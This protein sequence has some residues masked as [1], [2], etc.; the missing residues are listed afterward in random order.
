M[1]SGAVANVGLKVPKYL[2]CGTRMIHP[3]RD[4][5]AIMPFVDSAFLR[6]LD[7]V[8]FT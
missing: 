8:Y 2:I 6:V 1:L 3:A 5:T 7:A 4:V